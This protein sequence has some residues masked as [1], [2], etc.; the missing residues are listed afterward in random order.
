VNANHR[1]DSAV[2]N[3]AIRH[4]Y[5]P[6]FTAYWWWRTTLEVAGDMRD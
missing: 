1:H 3:T 5:T 6:A 4:A 2:M